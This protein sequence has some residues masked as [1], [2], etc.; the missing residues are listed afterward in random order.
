[1]GENFAEQLHA[2][3]KIDAHGA[4]GEA[5]ARGDFRPGHAL[6][7]AENERFAI[8]VGERAYGFEDGFG[9]G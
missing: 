7:E 6:D 5:G 9:F 1:M 4:V 3:M 8:S 2:A